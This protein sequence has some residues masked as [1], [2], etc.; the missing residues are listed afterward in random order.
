MS[1]EVHQLLDR[2]TRDLE[3][4]KET[5]EEE[6]WQAD[7]FGGHLHLIRPIIL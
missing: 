4:S 1:A 6:N 3:V 7:Y 5:I 2:N